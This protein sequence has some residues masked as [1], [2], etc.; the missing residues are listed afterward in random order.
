MWSLM[1]LNAKR[2]VWCFIF[3]LALRANKVKAKHITLTVG[4]SRFNRDYFDNFTF[5]L[6][7]GKVYLD[8][9]LKKPLIKGWYARLDFQ[10]RVPNS[11]SFQSIFST[12][13][14]VCNIVNVYKNNLF[15]KWYMNLLKYGNFLRQCPLSP[16]HYYLRGW[17]F[18][19][20][21]VPPF[22]SGGSYRLET[23]NFYGRYKSS[24]E[25]FIMS[26]SADATI[27]A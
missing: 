20:S 26:C 6:D 2:L 18:G 1:F 7:N 22:I 17:Q 8:M 16:G 27:T 4:E 21:L 14:N 9:F 10:L 5:V 19:N 15:K 23:Y 13:V 11:K 3:L 24:D 12:S 25:V